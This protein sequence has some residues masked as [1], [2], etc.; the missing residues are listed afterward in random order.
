M[1]VAAVSLAVNLAGVLFLFVSMCAAA[2]TRLRRGSSS[3]RPPRAAADQKKKDNGRVGKFL[4]KNSPSILNYKSK[5]F[6]YF[7]NSFRR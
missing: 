6:F 2:C 1:S 4:K 7:A 3:Y 5:F